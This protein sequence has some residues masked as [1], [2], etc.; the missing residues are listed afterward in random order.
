MRSAEKPRVAITRDEP[1]SGP[2]SLA[3]GRHGLEPVACSVITH[4][5]PRDPLP[6]CRAAARLAEFDWVVVSSARA[7]LALARASALEALREPPRWAVVGPATEAALARHGVSA[8]LTPRD[9]GAEALLAALLEAEAWSGRKVL[10][11]RAAGGRRS[12]AAGLRARGASVTEVI[13]YRTVARPR[14]A[15]AAAWRAARPQGVVVAS[16]SAVTAL[17]RAISPAELGRLPAVVAIGPT[18][19][20]ALRE[21][22]LGCSVAPRADFEAAAARC[23]ELL[24]LWPNPA[25]R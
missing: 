6:L 7:V 23:A 21:R 12:V 2:L 8:A 18:T 20:A 10:M 1:R 24:A 13:G 9:A 16:P 5:P 22:G 15:V 11:P 3:L 4:L 14:R 17:L 25:P 19:A